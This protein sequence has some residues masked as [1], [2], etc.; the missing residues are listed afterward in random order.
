MAK[1]RVTHYKP[2]VQVHSTKDG[3]L[4]INPKDV[5]FTS[6]GKENM[7]RIRL[8]FEKAR[9]EPTESGGEKVIR[10]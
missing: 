3:A 1:P 9:R 7:R 4:Y 8:L 2:K 5:L 10:S 6:E